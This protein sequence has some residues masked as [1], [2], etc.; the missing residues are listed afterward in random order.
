MSTIENER[1][2]H[3][4]FFQDSTNSSESQNSFSRL[5]RRFNFSAESSVA[6]SRRH[7]CLF[8]AAIRSVVRRD[9]GSKFSFSFSIFRFF[10]F[11]S[12]FQNDLTKINSSILFIEAKNQ[13]CEKLDRYRRR[14]KSRNSLIR[15]ES[16][17]NQLRMTEQ[18]KSR[19]RLTQ[20][21]IEKFLMVHI[22]HRFVFLNRSKTFDFISRN[23]SSI[24]SMFC[25]RDQ[26]KPTIRSTNKKLKLRKNEPSVLKRF[27]I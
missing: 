14:L 17:D 22:S 11:F 9:E 1:L 4:F 16:C 10:F 18:G 6:L 21:T 5:E 2:L 19:F 13:S 26:Q 7:S 24:L 12:S 25:R 23:K 20:Q 15:L 8:I 27:R 3:R